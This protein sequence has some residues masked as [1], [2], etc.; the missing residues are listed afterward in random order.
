MS[1]LM[2]ELPP[3]HKFSDFLRHAPVWMIPET[4]EHTGGSF[5]NL[6]YTRPML[7]PASERASVLRKHITSYKDC[8]AYVTG[9]RLPTK[10]SAVLEIGLQRDEGQT[11]ALPPAPTQASFDLVL[12]PPD[13]VADDPPP[14]EAP[15]TS[16]PF[17]IKQFPTY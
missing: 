16:V 13:D 17:G 6:I 14:P 9:Y 15:D 12:G 2:N 7:H 4:I 10:T 3:M 5:Y 11:L 1:K 8:F